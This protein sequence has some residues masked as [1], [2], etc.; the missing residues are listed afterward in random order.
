MGDVTV[1]FK[2]RRWC[3]PAGD[4]A[5]RQ[6]ADGVA[7]PINISAPGGW[8]AALGPQL[9][10]LADAGG[11]G[12]HAGFTGL[13]NI[14][15]EFGKFTLYHEIWT[16]WHINPFLN[17]QPLPSRA[18]WRR[19]KAGLPAVLDSISARIRAETAESGHF[20]ILVNNAMA[21]NLTKT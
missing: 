12:R 17:G 13:I 15:R 11:Q 5:V 6:A 14:A 20:V 8:M 9:D 3:L 16:S 19:M 21:K 4:P 1:R 10:V 7:V 2:Q 18:G